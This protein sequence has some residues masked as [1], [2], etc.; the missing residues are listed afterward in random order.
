[1]GGGMDSDK[2]GGWAIAFVSL[3][4]G[5]HFFLVPRRK[6]TGLNPPRK[7]GRLGAGSWAPRGLAQHKNTV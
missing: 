5:R 2:L 4:S 7:E 3:K 1:M 6:Q